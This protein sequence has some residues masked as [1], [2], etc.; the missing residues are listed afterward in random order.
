MSESARGSDHLCELLR[1]EFVVF[2]VE[3][4]QVLWDLLMLIV[5]GTEWNLLLVAEY[6]LSGIVISLWFTDLLCG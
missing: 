5:Q 6:Y 1:Q 4:M 3:L 2:G